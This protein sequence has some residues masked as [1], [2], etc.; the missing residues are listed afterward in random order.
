MEQF[1]AAGES[2]QEMSS[3]KKEI[4][5]ALANVYEDM[6]KSQEAKREY[7]KI[8]TVDIAFKDVAQKI[9]TKFR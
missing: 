3:L 2:L 1:Q 9:E 6:G 5:Y 4:L 7:Q 8:Y